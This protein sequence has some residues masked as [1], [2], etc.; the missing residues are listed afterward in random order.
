MSDGRFAAVGLVVPIAAVAVYWMWDPVVVPEPLD[1]V[2]RPIESPGGAEGFVPQDRTI[3]ESP[4]LRFERL[5]QSESRPEGTERAQPERNAPVDPTVR[6]TPEQSEAAESSVATSEQAI[7]RY[8]V[9]SGD[10]LSG[11]SF[12]EYG[13]SRYVDLIFEANRDVLPSQNALAV[14]QQL[15]LPPLPESGER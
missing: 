2:S 6:S 14:G 9:R 8:T 7:R 10:T 13:S 5:E 12:R 15:V 1:Q 4:G 11:I 3:L